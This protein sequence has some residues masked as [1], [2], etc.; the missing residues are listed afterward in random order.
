MTN[1]ILYVFHQ[2]GIRASL[3]EGEDGARAFINNQ[4][5]IP[6]TEALAVGFRW[7]VPSAT[8]RGRRR[9]VSHFYSG[10]DR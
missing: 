3:H 4:V 1:A 10:Q 6:I 8:P 9:D 2:K 7:P 5:Y